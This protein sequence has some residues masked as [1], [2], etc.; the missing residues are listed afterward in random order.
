MRKKAQ[1]AG[2]TIIWI[3]TIVIGSMILVFGFRY[4]TQTKETACLAKSTIF[5]KDLIPDIELAQ[6]QPGSVLERDYGVP[7]D[8][9]KI[10]FM[11]KRIMDAVDFSSYSFSGYAE[12]VDSL[13][14]KVD[15]NLFLVK[16]GKVEGS[17]NAGSVSI[18]DPYYSCYVTKTG[19]LKL[20]LEGK[21]GETKIVNMDSRLDCTTS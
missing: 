15:K 21:K 8:I 19:K 6:N 1:F 9:E 17:F 16:N 12:V 14:S 11:D 13:Q 10:F 5:K 7:C 18:D 20:F 3:A 4:L 2:R